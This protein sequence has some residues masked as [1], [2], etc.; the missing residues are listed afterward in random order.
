MNNNITQFQTP[1]SNRLIKWIMEG[2]NDWFEKKKK[3]FLLKHN[4]NLYE[5]L[6]GKRTI[7]RI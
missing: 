3:E 1:I 5:K 7:T 6:Y 4:P 2:N